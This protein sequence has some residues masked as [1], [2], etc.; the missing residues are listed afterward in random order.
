MIEPE[1]TLSVRRQSLLLG[2]NR[3]SLYYKKKI[4]ADESEIMNL[5]H[6]IWLKHPTMGYRAITQSLNK[7]YGITS[8]MDFHSDNEGNLLVGREVR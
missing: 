1:G 2:L 6:E 3:S 5:I 8:N 7:Q 4:L